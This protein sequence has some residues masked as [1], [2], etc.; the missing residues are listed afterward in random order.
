MLVQ[1]EIKTK[2]KK[3]NKKKRKT[4]EGAFFFFFRMHVCS[5]KLQDMRNQW[6]SRLDFV[7]CS[8]RRRLTYFYEPNTADSAMPEAG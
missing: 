4:V 6:F 5:N 3:K 1:V 8:D 7:L 2:T